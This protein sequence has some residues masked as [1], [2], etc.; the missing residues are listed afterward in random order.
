MSKQYWTPLALALLVFGWAIPTWGANILG[1]TDP[2]LA[3]DFDVV[4]NSSYPGGEAPFNALDEDPNTKYLNFGQRNSG[5]IV[6]PVFGTS[7]VQS[8]YFTTANDAVERDPASYALWGTNEAIVSADNSD[9]TGENWTLIT[10]GDVSLP[11]DR[12]TNG[13]VISFANAVSFTSY[14]LVF[15]SVKDNNSANSMQIAD[16]RFFQSTDATGTSV[17]SFF[18]DARAI[19]FPTP[20]SK[21]PANEAPLN[22]LDGDTS[23]K[24]LNFG[25]ENS[26]F[27]VTPVSGR[28]AVR[29]FQISTA[30]DFE[31]R[32]PATWELYG[33]DETIVSTDNS[34][35]MG[36]NWTLVDSGAVALPPDRFTAGPV[37]PVNN[38]TRYSSY[39]MVIKTV[40]DTAGV[41][42]DSTQYSEVQFFETPNGNDGDFN[43][44]AAW[45]CAD[46]D[47]LVAEIVAATNNV[48]FDLTGDALVTSADLDMWLK[49]GGANNPAQTNGNPFVRG[50]AN[51]SGSVDGSD[52]GVWNANKFTNVAA[53]CS[54]DF[55]ASGSV[56]GSD[57][58]VW[59][60]NKFT[61]SD[62]VAAVPEPTAWFCLVAASLLMTLRRTR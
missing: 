21:Y 8:M 42:V 36:E 61:S 44:D 59:N 49:E 37:V 46:V 51:L 26:G 39:R 28:R 31:G 7:V 16:I 38:D 30:N 45:N 60:A 43:G 29:G 6:T 50:D 19:H 55:N 47:S 15:P 22:A 52:F 11:D 58:G 1:P 20:E 24:Y 48:A 54:G 23:T 12:F 32:D 34:T 9:G 5:L 4:S 56:D 13:P 3:F 10:Q 57:F 2:I 35:G 62:G 27:I 33:T 41:G 18:D 14:R 25:K 53:W 40:K 17:L